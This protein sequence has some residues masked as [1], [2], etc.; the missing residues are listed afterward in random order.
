MA[1]II[2]AGNT[3]LFINIMSYNN[4]LSVTAYLVVISL[5]FLKEYLFTHPIQKKTT[6]YEDIRKKITFLKCTLKI[7][8]ASGTCC[9]ASR[10]FLHYFLAAQPLHPTI[11]VPVYVSYMV[12]SHAN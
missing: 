11:Y 8:L 9:K 10:H 6:L 4:A 7:L 1:I 12:I 3:V 2:Q 5:V